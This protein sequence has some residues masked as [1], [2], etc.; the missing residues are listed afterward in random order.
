MR[1]LFHLPASRRAAWVEISAAGE[2]NRWTRLNASGRG[3]VEANADA[4][5]THYPHYDI[6]PD[7]MARTLLESYRD[8]GKLVNDAWKALADV[9]GDHEA[10]S[11]LIAW[12][13]RQSDLAA[14]RDAEALAAWR[15]HPLA[16]GAIS[17]ARPA[18]RGMT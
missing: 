1:A 10:T 6:D 14:R 16:G 15:H 3:W 7:R 2:G 9:L 11:Y 13:A 17:M 12:A 8:G 4:Y 5:R 18:S